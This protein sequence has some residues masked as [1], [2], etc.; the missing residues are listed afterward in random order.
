[1]CVR[2]CIYTFTMSQKGLEHTVVVVFVYSA[3]LLLAFFCSVHATHS[4]GF[5]S[6]EPNCLISILLILAYFFVVVVVE[7]K[8]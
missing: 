6:L 7:L 4:V 2:V 1:M 8:H 5:C 3:L